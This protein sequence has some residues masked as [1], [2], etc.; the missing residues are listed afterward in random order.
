M[1]A[2]QTTADEDAEA[3]IKQIKN[4]SLQEMQDLVTNMPFA[5]RPGDPAA[6]KWLEIQ[7]NLK[8]AEKKLKD[9]NLISR[10]EV[11]TM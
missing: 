9:K 11:N 8:A 6:V 4:M 7:A 10:D 5:T 1:P 2:S 3:K